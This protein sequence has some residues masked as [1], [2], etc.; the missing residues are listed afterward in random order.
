MK[1]NF[2]R[3]DAALGA[4]WL[5]GTY[6]KIRQISMPDLGRCRRGMLSQKPHHGLV[7][8]DGQPRVSTHALP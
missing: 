3:Q 7:M 8:R 5:V 1:G 2:G 6:A 4:L